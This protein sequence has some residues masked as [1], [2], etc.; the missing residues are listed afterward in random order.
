MKISDSV[1][2]TE[3]GRHALQAAIRRLNE[4]LEAIALKAAPTETAE[5]VPVA[6]TP[7]EVAHRLRKSRAWVYQ[8]MADGSLPFSQVSPRR[9]LIRL[10]DL[11]AFLIAR[12]R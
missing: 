10:E 11:E 2:I 9:R 7:L 6:L 8:R 4:T 5:A 3:T 1:L 12:R